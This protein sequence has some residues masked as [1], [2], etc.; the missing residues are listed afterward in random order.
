MSADPRSSATSLAS[1]LVDQLPLAACVLDESRI[2][3]VNERLCSLL[4][5]TK[6]QIVG[7]PDALQTVLIPI[8]RKAGAAE[9]A[10]DEMD[11]VGRGSDGAPIPLRG[12]ISPFPLAGPG[13]VLIVCTDERG[14]ARTAQIVRGL[15][16]AAVAAQREQTALG[17]FRSVR[18]RLAQLGLLVNFNEISG[19]AVHTLDLGDG[20]GGLSALRQ[21]WAH[22]IPVEAF[23]ALLPR[24]GHASQG[25]LIEDLP[26]LI[27]KALGKRR[28]EVDPT[29]PSRAIYA[30]IPVSGE[31]PSYALSATGSG[32]DATVASAFGLFGQQVGAFLEQIRR[33]EELD[34]KNRELAAVN[35]VARASAALGSADSLR[36]A[37]D[38]F[39][40]VAGVERTAILRREEDSLEL[41]AQRGFEGHEF[42][43]VLQ[44]VAIDRELPWTDAALAGDPVLFTKTLSSMNASL[45]S[46]KTSSWVPAVYPR[47]RRSRDPERYLEPSHREF[48]LW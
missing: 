31:G 35:E 44:S 40:E 23:R 14:L 17:L 36:Q 42:A 12:R 7:A 8:S 2:V 41:A 16:D 48:P 34:R 47:A 15:V 25:N 20:P 39:A 37:L 1:A 9:R 22:D 26:G 27:A 11:L 4:G 21:R 13:A 32:L 38:R 46:V 30:I 29:I 18:D 3:A 43:A 24:K 28:D 19:Q 10:V 33:I 45:V 6:E 5:R